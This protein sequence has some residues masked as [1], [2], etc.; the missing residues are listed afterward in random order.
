MAD[1]LVKLRQ[2]NKDVIYVA[3]GVKGGFY[4]VFDGPTSDLGEIILGGPHAKES[5]AQHEAKY[6]AADFGARLLHHG[7]GFGQ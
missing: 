3:R 2:P 5:S 4:V 7:W 1:N 6:L